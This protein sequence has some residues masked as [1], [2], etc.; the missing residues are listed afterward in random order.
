VDHRRS[1]VKHTDENRSGEDDKTSGARFFET[2]S[3]RGLPPPSSTAAGSAGRSKR[4]SE[5]ELNDALRVR[6]HIVDSAK[7]RIRLSAGR[8]VEHGRGR[9]VPVD[10]SVFE[11]NFPGLDAKANS[12]IKYMVIACGTA[13]GLLGVNRQF[14]T[15]LKTKNVRFTD[16]EVPDLGH[17][18]PLWRQ[19]LT[20]FVQTVFK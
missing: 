10:A 11:M 5:S 6:P 18:W 4:E 15:W 12:R 7:V 2:L 9:G 14:K 20:D 17:V 13:D 8:E 3:C 1:S 19:N 16:V